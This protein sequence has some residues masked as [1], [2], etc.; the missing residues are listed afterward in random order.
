MQRLSRKVWGWVIASAVF[1]G[2]MGYLYSTGAFGDGSVLLASL[3][4]ET[5]PIHIAVVIPEKQDDTY[6]EVENGGRC[7]AENKCQRWVNGHPI[8]VDF[9]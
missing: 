9:I 4:G 8:Q 7:C 6:P 1:F 3:E 5:T 2:S